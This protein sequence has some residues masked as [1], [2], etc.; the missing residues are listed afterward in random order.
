MHVHWCLEN[1][2]IARFLATVSEPAVLEAAGRELTELNE[3]FAAALVG[4]WRPHAHYGSLRPLTPA[5]A[6][7]LWL[8]P[9]QERVRTWL[10]GM[11]PEPPT[12]AD[13]EVLADAAWR[14]LRAGDA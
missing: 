12:E 13:V 6:E 7:A 3:R 4:W 14:S 9:A 8:G 2:G 10:L 11:I 5:Q 1:P